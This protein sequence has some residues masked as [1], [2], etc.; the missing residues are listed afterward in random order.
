MREERIIVTVVHVIV[1]DFSYHIY[2]ILIH[3]A[4]GMC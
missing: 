4:P 1:T 2:S 3:S